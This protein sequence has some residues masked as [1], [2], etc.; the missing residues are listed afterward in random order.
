MR[1]QAPGYAG[2]AVIAAAALAL[3]LL[4]ATNRARGQEPSSAD[5][6][7]RAEALLHERAYGPAAELLRAVLSSD[8][9]NRRARELFAFAL[10][11]AGARDEERRVRASL[12]RDFPGDPEIQAAYGRVLERSGR[13]DEALA[14]YR[15]ARSLRPAPP[16]ADLDAAI[17][18]LEGRTSIEFAAPVETLADPDATGARTGAGAAIPLGRVGHL[19]LTAG[20]ATAEAREGPATASD[21]R[22]AASV[23]L[24]HP[25]GASLIVGPR[26]QS[27]SLDDGGLEDAAVGGL[28]AVRGPLGRWFSADLS[29]AARVPWDEA[30]VAILHGGRSDEAQAHLYAALWNRR[31]IL[32]VG[33]QERRLSIL[34]P[35]TGAADPGATLRPEAT[36]TLLLAGADVVLWRKTGATTR[37]ELLDDALVSPAVHPAMVM[38]GYRHY[39]VTTDTE[40][41]FAT[42]IDLAPRGVVDEISTTIGLFTP[43]GRF[44]VELRGGLGRDTERDARLSRIG[45]SFVWTPASAVRLALGYD[46]ASDLATGLTGRRSAG[47]FSLHVDF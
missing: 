11:S 6:L 28:F 35:D 14:A 46:E 24:R 23:V 30:P 36:Q 13:G 5:R 27:V 1:R 22:L 37:G 20:R 12:A 43:R 4:G 47:T 8:P 15:R 32:Q 21:D 18:R 45:G 9:G 39:D 38:L 17:D 29:A 10:E 41:G 25:S 42:V 44:G 2:R 33:G 40:P 26:Y 34:T 19:S 16:D 31:L 7:A 3:T